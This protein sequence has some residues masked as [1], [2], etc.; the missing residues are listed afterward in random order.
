MNITKFKVYSYTICKKNDCKMIAK[1]LQ[2]RPFAA[3]EKAKEISFLR[4]FCDF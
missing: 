1:F 3:K 2:K 4:L